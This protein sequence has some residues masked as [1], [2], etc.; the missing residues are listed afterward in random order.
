MSKRYNAV[1]DI[2]DILRILL[3]ATKHSE[4]IHTTIC[5][6]GHLDDGRCIPT[7]ET[8]LGII[9]GID[10]GHIEKR[11]GKSH[12]DLVR[13]AMKT[14]MAD[15]IETAATDATVHTMERSLTDTLK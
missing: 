7:S 3:V 1:Y 10:P 2:W 6:L 11:D 5:E 13:Y 15:N 8:A 14:G 12:A 9:K 4:F